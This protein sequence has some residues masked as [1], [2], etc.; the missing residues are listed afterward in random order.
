MAEQNTMTEVVRRVKDFNQRIRDLEEKVRNLNAR[1]NTVEDTLLERTKK[2][3]N[4]LAD[5]TDEIG[6]L[7]DRAANLEVDIKN[8][9][10]NM[11]KMVTKREISEIENYLDLMEPVNSAFVTENEVE[12]MLEE[13]AGGG[14]SKYEVNRMIERKMDELRK[15]MGASE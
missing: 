5:L 13:Q 11:R 14:I 15:E 4:E 1:V 12:Q 6:T 7:H 10:R 9:Q 3:N 2:L 8:V